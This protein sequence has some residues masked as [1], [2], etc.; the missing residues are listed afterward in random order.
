MPED[1]VKIRVDI[2]AGKLKATLEKLI[3]DLHE[4]GVIGKKS[5]D[6]LQAELKQT[7]AA[8]KE[9]ATGMSKFRK[10]FT[11]LAIGGGAFVGISMLTSKIR[12]LVEKSKEFVKLAVDERIAIANLE[13]GLRNVG[14]AR[15]ENIKRLVE[16]ADKLQRLTGVSNTE[17]L[18][19]Q[20]MLTTFAL[21]S[22]EI[23][24]LTPQLVNMA[25]AFKK[26]GKADADI[27]QIAIAIGKAVTMGAGALTRY[28]IVVTE[29][30]KKQL[31]AAQGMEKIKLLTEILAQNFNK[32]GESTGRADA[33]ISRLQAALD[34]LKKQLG[35][36]IVDVMQPL[37]NKLIP[38]VYEAVDWVKNNKAGI[39][40]FFNDL[41][42]LG[43]GIYR[44]FSPLLDLFKSIAQE[45]ESLMVGVSTART[46]YL[47]MQWGLQALA[48]TGMKAKELEKFRK[49]LEYITR[50]DL[51][52]SLRNIASVMIDII[53]KSTGGMSLYEKW[54]NKTFKVTLDKFMGLEQLLKKA[55]AIIREKSKET[56]EDVGKDIDNLA[57]KGK[58]AAKETADSF[59]KSCDDIVTASDRATKQLIKDIKAYREE[60]IGWQYTVAGTWM[61]IYEKKP[62]KFSLKDLQ[63]DISRISEIADKST[64][65]FT[66]KVETLGDKI[67]NKFTTPLENLLTAMIEKP[68]EMQSAWL[69][70]INTVKH[71]LAGMFAKYLVTTLFTGGANFVLPFGYGGLLPGRLLTAA[72]GLIVNKPTLALIGERQESNPELVTP[73]RAFT[74]WL[75]ETFGD[76]KNQDYIIVMDGEKV[77]RLV[78]KHEIKYKR[79]TEHVVT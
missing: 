35:H 19:A 68:T 16:Q 39:K 40:A 46:A 65:D 2:D 47:R 70:F 26:M 79:L 60:I 69:D 58:K 62:I 36:I 23:E 41:I 4:T 57:D 20:K 27:Q 77:G 21:T 53:D 29:T 50:S 71:E 66:E 22:K 8:A 17:I 32:F 3:K 37:I 75:R 61:P 59:A 54:T 24:M 72:E 1:R 9:A 42:S 38:K 64:K 13:Q 14:D 49:E 56:T 15:K 55:Y 25:A 34:D 11:G 30:Q 31:R 6:K 44:A 33:G 73:K 67:K 28:G 7:T 12:G 51:P 48:T 52:D 78:K 76:I 5:F 63:S 74:E 10:L 43:K 45:K 18:H